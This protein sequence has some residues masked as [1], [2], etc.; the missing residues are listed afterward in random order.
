MGYLCSF[1]FLFIDKNDTRIA[2]LCQ[3]YRTTIDLGQLGKKG[4][5][6]WAFAAQATMLSGNNGHKEA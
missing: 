1:E 5:F 4:P 2:M 3:Q 6:N